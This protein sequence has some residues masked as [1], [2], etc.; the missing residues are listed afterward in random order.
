MNIK[1]DDGM[2]KYAGTLEHS[3]SLHKYLCLYP[4]P[5]MYPD[6]SRY[7]SLAELSV[8]QSIVTINIKSC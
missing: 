6:Q 1:I 7:F 3:V 2:N 8:V 5:V 4:N